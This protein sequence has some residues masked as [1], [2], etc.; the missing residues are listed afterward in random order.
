MKGSDTTRESNRLRAFFVLTGFLIPSI[1]VALGLTFKVWDWP[2]WVGTAYLILWPL[3]MFYDVV[4][5]DHGGRMDGAMV[6]LLGVFM[7]TNA[8]YFFFVAI[9]F[10][11]VRRIVFRIQGSSGS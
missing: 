11:F 10:S 1:I 7:L 8:L 3:D 4:F 9:L 5:T 6:W 2:S